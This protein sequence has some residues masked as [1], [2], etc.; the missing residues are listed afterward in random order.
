MVFDSFNLKSTI[1]EMQTFSKAHVNSIVSNL[2]ATA[3][4]SAVFDHLR[5][6]NLEPNTQLAEFRHIPERFLL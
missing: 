5:P 6:N 4:Y 3:S 2:K 1:S